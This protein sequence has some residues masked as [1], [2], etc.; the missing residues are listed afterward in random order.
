M[1]IR[2]YKNQDHASVISI[3]SMNKIILFISFVSF[4]LIAKAQTADFSYQSSDGL[5]CN[6]TTVQFT[7]TST[8]NPIGFV[9]NF[10][11]G[12]GSNSPNPVI[13]YMNGGSY[14]VKL[15]VIYARSTVVVTKTI[16]INSS[17]TTSIGYDR[18]YICKPG[19]INFTATGGGIAEYDW[20]F[21]DGSGIETTTANNITH[22][23]AAPGVYTVTL[24]A[25]AL[26]GCDATAQTTITVQTPP[27][28]GTVTPGSG[29]IPANVSFTA[30]A[31]IP[32]NSTVTN[33]SWDFGDGSPVVS[34]ITKNINH[35]YP[36]RR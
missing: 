13:T 2:N 24:K 14:T 21:G 27:I 10:G 33:Y 8:G 32:V 12:A 30:N 26:S 7:Q 11:N 20:D 5:F 28:T 22:N 34:T 18:N 16:I 19:V 31:T 29:C 23:Y 15:I 25:K 17:I 3:Q 36:A 9:W 4:S 6:P 35:T 1:N